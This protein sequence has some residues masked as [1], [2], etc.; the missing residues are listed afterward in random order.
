M[1]RPL[2]TDTDR[3]YAGG[4]EMGELVRS[5]DWSTTPLGRIERRLDARP[6]ELPRSP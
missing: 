2:A 3:I 5:F 6:L 4:G 1:I